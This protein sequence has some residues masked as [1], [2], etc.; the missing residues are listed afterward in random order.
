MGPEAACP[1]LMELDREERWGGGE[2]GEAPSAVS[3]WDHP[4]AWTGGED[5]DPEA[6]LLGLDLDFFLLT[7]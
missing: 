1:Y 3:T 5:V 7:W 6:R 4:A 2:A